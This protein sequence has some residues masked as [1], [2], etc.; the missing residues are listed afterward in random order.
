MFGFWH[1][2]VCGHTAPSK[3]TQLDCQLL[4]MSANVGTIILLI[5]LLAS[6]VL[7]DST[8]IPNGQRHVKCQ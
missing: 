1:H 7:N 8:S 5:R 2:V 3:D 4:L 6:S